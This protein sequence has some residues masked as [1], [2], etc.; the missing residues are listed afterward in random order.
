MNWEELTKKT[1]VPKLTW[2]MS[3]LERAGI[4]CRL[5]GE[6]FLAPILEVDSA[7]FDRA[8]RVLGPVDG[9]S[10]DDSMFENT[11]W[12]RAW[13]LKP[14][15]RATVG[16]LVGGIGLLANKVR[17]AIAAGVGCVPG[18]AVSKIDCPL[19]I[20][21]IERCPGGLWSVCRPMARIEIHLLSMSEELKT[22]DE[23]ALARCQGLFEA[24]TA[25]AGGANPSDHMIAFCHVL[26]MRMT[27]GRLG[28]LAK[29]AKRSSVGVVE[30]VM[31][32]TI[33]VRGTVVPRRMEVTAADI[34]ARD[35]EQWDLN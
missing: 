32:E 10:D 14:P 27:E 23:E 35:Q 15:R 31:R 9:L 19:A 29:L 26:S 8:W 11:E 12:A 28:R 33:E 20:G 18:D 34:V 7:E 17:R 24:L 4:S 21:Q 3:A 1:E 30:D 13:W 6:S 16:A 2:V 25:T 5:N 22:N